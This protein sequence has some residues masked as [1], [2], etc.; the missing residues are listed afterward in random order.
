[1]NVLIDNNL[2]PALA[3]ALDALAKREGDRVEHLRSR[4]DASTPDQEWIEELGQDEN[5][6]V[7]SEDRRLTRNRHERE[8][9]RRNGIT[10]FVL[11]KAW[12]HQE[13]WEKASRLIGRW[14]DI[15]KQAQMVQPGAIFEVPIGRTSKFRQL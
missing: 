11:A 6:V 1:M 7:I 15:I 4:F 14:P 12:K 5:W 3:E 13:Y 2:P 8:A 10:T 9:L